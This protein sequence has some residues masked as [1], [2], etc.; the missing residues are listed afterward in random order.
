MNC[1]NY[2]PN[3]GTSLNPIRAI[4]RSQDQRSR[5]SLPNM[6]AICANVGRKE[7]KTEPK[8]M[9]TIVFAF[10][11]F[12][13]AFATYLYATQQRGELFSPPSPNGDEVSYERLGYNLAAG[14]GFGYCPNAMSPSDTSIP[15]C[16]PECSPAQFVVTAYRPPGF[17]F[18]VAAIYRL[19]PQNYFLV[20]C[21]N[22]VCLALAVACVASAFFRQFSI[23]DG[24]FVGG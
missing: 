24:I 10:A 19:S 12:C 13:A 9:T 18:F 17:P 14:L 6:R 22:C 23:F 20:R 1:L 7:P 21:G 11:V 15:Q 3:E 4:A 8:A 2:P 16:K 5:W